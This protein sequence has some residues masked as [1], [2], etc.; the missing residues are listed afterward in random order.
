MTFASR[1]PSPR[2]TNQDAKKNSVSENTRR[3]T[4]PQSPPFPIGWH[5]GIPTPEE[6]AKGRGVGLS[7]ATEDDFLMLEKAPNRITLTV[8][9][10]GFIYPMGIRYH[11]SWTGTGG[12]SLNLDLREVGHTMLMTALGPHNDPSMLL[13]RIFSKGSEMTVK[14][15]STG[16]TWRI[17]VPAPPDD[18]HARFVLSGAASGDD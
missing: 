5:L 13:F 9:E 18:L 14:V 16:H 1:L 4:K 17:R 3:S 6:R 12:H 7:Y 8:A 11:A 2:R 15:P 10:Y